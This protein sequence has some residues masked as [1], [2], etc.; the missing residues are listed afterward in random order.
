MVHSQGRWSNY[1]RHDCKPT[2]TDYRAELAKAQAKISL[3][4]QGKPWENELAESFNDALKQEEVWL[5]EYE[6]YQQVEQN[7]KEWV[8]EIYD[9]LRLHS[10]LGYPP[11]AEYEEAWLAGHRN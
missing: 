4:G 7:L 11:P 3:A 5:Q 9:K 8:E 10:S 6:S 2:S 1:H